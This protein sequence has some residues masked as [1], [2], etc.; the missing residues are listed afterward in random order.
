M[1]EILLFG[2]IMSLGLI[3]W[4]VL[5]GIIGITTMVEHYK[6]IKTKIIERR[7]YNNFYR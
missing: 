6:K 7:R 2:L 4:I 5:I 1:L 3:C